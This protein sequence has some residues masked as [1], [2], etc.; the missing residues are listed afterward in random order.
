MMH[1][2]VL[3]LTYFQS[4]QVLIPV[5]GSTK[6]ATK[7]SQRKNNISGHKALNMT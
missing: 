3:L 6:V 5:H 4:L 1:M 7:T 2:A